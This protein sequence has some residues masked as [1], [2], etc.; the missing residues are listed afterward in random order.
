MQSEHAD[1]YIRAPEW[2]A[3]ADLL[4]GECIGSVEGDVH[5]RHRK[6]IRPAFGVPETRALLPVFNGVANKV[7]APQ[8]LSRVP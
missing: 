5:R 7:R 3:M 2:Y 8:I 1:K 6:G 4:A